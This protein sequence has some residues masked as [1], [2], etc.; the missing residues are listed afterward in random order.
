MPISP[1]AGKPA[2][3][4]MLV[5]VARLQREYCERHPDLHDPTSL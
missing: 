5:D 3:Q 1:L 4:E 2:P